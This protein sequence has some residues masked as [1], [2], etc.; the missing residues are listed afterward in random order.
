M[1]PVR[2]YGFRPRQRS[3][4]ERTQ[5]TTGQKKVKVE[6]IKTKTGNRNEGREDKDKKIKVKRMTIRTDE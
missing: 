4:D 6:R 1:L 5:K 3:D 2:E